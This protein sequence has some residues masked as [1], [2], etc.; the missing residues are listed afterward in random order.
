LPGHTP[1]LVS[2]ILDPKYYDDMENIPLLVEGCDTIL[3]HF[4]R[5]V[6]ERRDQPYLGSRPVTGKDEK[7][8][9]TFGDYEW[10]SW[11]QVSDIS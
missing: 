9:D 5:Q 2:S 1:E 11:K 6:A 7:G 3:K 8:K 4:K 10:K